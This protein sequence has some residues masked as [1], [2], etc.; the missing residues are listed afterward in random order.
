MCKC[1][2]V[3]TCSVRLCVC[4]Y[5]HVCVCIC[6]VCV[7]VS[8]CLCVCVHRVAVPSCV[9]RR[10]F[11]PCTSRSWGR[12]SQLVSLSLLLQPPHP[13]QSLF[14]GG[15]A[16][17]L[18]LRPMSI[19]SQASL[20]C[21]CQPLQLH[22]AKKRRGH[23]VTPPCGSDVNCGDAFFLLSLMSISRSPVTEGEHNT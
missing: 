5:V 1:R 21:F 10:N 2:C 12:M 17:P 8:L 19:F 16:S 6:V 13:S 3:T 22:N 18:F 15:I 23:K 4:V 14:P 20:C 11:L 9:H 7:P